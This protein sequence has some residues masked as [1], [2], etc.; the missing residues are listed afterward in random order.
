MRL[1]CSSCALTFRVPDAAIAEMVTCPQCGT[2]MLAMPPVSEAEVERYLHGEGDVPLGQD[3]AEYLPRPTRLAPVVV[4]GTFMIVLALIGA[5]WYVWANERKK[6]PP[7]PAPA[8]KR[9]PAPVQRETI[10]PAGEDLAAKGVL[11]FVLAFQAAVCVSVVAW[12]VFWVLACI[13]VARDSRRRLGDSGGIWV[14]VLILTGIVGVWPVGLLVYVASRP[15][16]PLVP[17]SNCG[18]DRLAF[19]KLCP[20]C[21]IRIA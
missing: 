12:F 2:A 15:S 19:A 11:G 13:W 17:C 20:H 9:E 16:G 6:D 21:A 5:G 7:T 10:T 3:L 18:L 8:T 14:V 4:A 1:P